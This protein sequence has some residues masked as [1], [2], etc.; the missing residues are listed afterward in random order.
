L[1]RGTEAFSLGI[2]ADRRKKLTQMLRSKT[3]GIAVAS[4]LCCAENNAFAQSRSDKPEKVDEAA[5]PM[6]LGAKLVFTQVES[7]EQ[8]LLIR[9]QR[10]ELTNL[11]MWFKNEGQ[12]P[13][14]L[15]R[16]GT[17]LVLTDKILTREEEE[18]EFNIAAKQWSFPLDGE[19]EPGQTA[20]FASQNGIDDEGW[21]E[22]Q[23]K[24]KYL[25]S[26][27]AVTYRAEGADSE[28]EVVTEAC[29][30]FRNADLKPVN[31]CEAD[32]NRVVEREK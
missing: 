12:S 25:Y 11:K 27:L 29:V 26:F 32:H 17:T 30:W 6:T 8:F 10:L 2:R 24:R 15:L 19:V 7:F 31:S 3:I 28:K 18:N 1:T 13:A 5:K 4:L 14:R 22:L 20:S 23:A 21:A 9:D 16:L